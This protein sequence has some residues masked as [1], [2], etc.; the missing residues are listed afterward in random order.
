MA[1]DIANELDADQ[2]VLWLAREGAC[3]GEAK[4]SRV[5]VDRL[6]EAMDG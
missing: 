4:S 1:M 6:V 3:I 5:S 2:I